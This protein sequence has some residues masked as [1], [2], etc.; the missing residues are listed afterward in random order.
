[1]AR[2][3]I[4]DAPKPIGNAGRHRRRHAQRLMLAHE[5]VEG[6]IERERMNVRIDLFRECVGRLCEATHMHAHRKVLELHQ[7]QFWRP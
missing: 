1:M 2:H 3:D 5:I 6:E 7:S 4:L